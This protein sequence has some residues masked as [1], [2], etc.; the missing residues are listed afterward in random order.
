MQIKQDFSQTELFIRNISRLQRAVYRSEFYV[1]RRS[2]LRHCFLREDFMLYLVANKDKSV[3]TGEAVAVDQWSIPG[4]HA[5]SMLII[6]YEWTRNVF[7]YLNQFKRLQRAIDT[8]DM[9][10]TK[11]TIQ[12][13]KAPSGVLFIYHT[14]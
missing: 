9:C 10:S 4:W 14:A 11:I 6:I 3:G 2:S 7:S 5:D 8:C 13:S 12:I 1:Y